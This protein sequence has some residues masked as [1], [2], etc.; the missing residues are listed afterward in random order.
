MYD[1]PRECR[2]SS[3]SPDGK[4]LFVTEYSSE[5]L[6]P[7]TSADI[8]VLHLG[9]DGEKATREPLYQGPS[10]QFSPAVS[11]NGRWVAFA[12]GHEGQG[13]GVYV[14]SIAGAGGVYSVSSD[15]GSVSRWSPD[16]KTLYFHEN[17]GG[18]R[19]LMAAEVLS[20][21][22]A[23]SDDKQATFEIGEIKPV[24]D[25]GTDIRAWQI[26]PDGKS[27]L[28]IAL[29]QKEGVEEVV[30]DLAVIHVVR[31]FFTEL[32]RLAPAKK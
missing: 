23:G 30:D 4:D 1:G 19:R 20:G 16:G 12:S 24:F 22:D 32:E 9:V 26:M 7:G 13:A 6:S 11:P 3:I 5:E 15:G 25:L 17:S 29:A 21:A 2:V 8:A 28:V 18:K 10:F 31:N 27:L 14:K